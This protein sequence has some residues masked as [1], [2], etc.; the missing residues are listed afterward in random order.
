MLSIPAILR[1]MASL[2]MSLVEC[3]W[4]KD[5]RLSWFIHSPQIAQE[6]HAKD[7]SVITLA[8]VGGESTVSGGMYSRAL[9]YIRNLPSGES[10]FHGRE[11]GTVRPSRSSEGKMFTEKREMFTG[12]LLLSLKSVCS[13]RVDLQWMHDTMSYGMAESWKS[14]RKKTWKSFHM[15]HPACISWSQE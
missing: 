14:E 3:W 15:K 6:V 5:R 12:S 1:A 13:C 7:E 10:I 8:N 11:G 9:K 2:Q 4:A